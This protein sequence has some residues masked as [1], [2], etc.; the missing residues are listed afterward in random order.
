MPR[1]NLQS[2]PKNQT[3]KLVKPELATLTADPFNRKGWIFEIKW[4]GFRAIAD[5]KKPGILLYSRN[6]L[7]FNE[8]FA[9]IV[10]SLQKARHPMVLDG[11]V[12]VLDHTGKSNFQLL[13]NY[14]QQPQGRLIYYCFDILEFNGKDLKNLPLIE[15]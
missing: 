10:K 9:P 7:S 1:I 14:Q 6:H 5:V 4:D 11:E 8:I 15:R 2:I 3:S 13:Q 12:V